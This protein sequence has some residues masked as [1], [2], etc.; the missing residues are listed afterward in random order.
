MKRFWPRSLT[1][2]LVLLLV[3]TLCVAQIMVL[4]LSASDRLRVIDTVQ[5]R[6]TWSATT[7]LVRL[8]DTS[9]RSDWPRLAAAFDRRRLAVSVSDEPAV[10]RSAEQL[11]GPANGI[12]RRLPRGFGPV[13]IEVNR[14]G[15]F[16]SD[17]WRRD[18]DDEID[19]DDERYEERK[20][21][22]RQ[23][24]DR[25]R[26]VIAIALPD[27][28]WLNL[29]QRLRPPPIWSGIT[30]GYF[31]LSAVLISLVAYLALRRLTR[32]LR[33]L[34]DAAERFGRSAEPEALPVQGP[35]EL[36]KAAT[37]FNE[38]AARISRFVQDRTAMIAAISHDLRTPI[39]SLKLRAEFVEDEE[40][41]QKMLETLDDMAAMTQATL[42]FA[43]Q[44][45]VTEKLQP[46][47]LNALLESLADDLRDQDMV[48]DT[49]ALVTDGD[50]QRTIIQ[51]RPAAIK[52]VFCNLIENAVRYGERATLA[53]EPSSKDVRVTIDDLGPGIAPVDQERVFEPFTRLETSRNRETGGT[54]LGLAIARTIVHAHGGRI[55]L[56][57]LERGLR[58][59]VILPIS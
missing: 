46:L 55:E 4:I 24:Q 30:W 28:R 5:T 52:R 35:I 27:G 17:H 57:N 26:M 38:M 2:R 51:A 1:G 32:P 48:I 16:D 7:A 34:A 29:Q 22:R 10:E 42:D 11:D 59:T 15:F 39:T 21:R 12:A 43:R 54:G 13:L 53:I 31:I 18:D 44:D 25:A 33:A 19:D 47:D 20:N 45:A 14:R 6:E 8:F 58:A 23:T 41:R 56:T 50:I 9:P 36:R 3:L 40:N 49:A 37:A